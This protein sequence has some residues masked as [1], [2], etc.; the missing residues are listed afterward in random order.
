MTKKLIKTM[1]LVNPE[2][3]AIVDVVLVA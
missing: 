1:V 3:L 2:V